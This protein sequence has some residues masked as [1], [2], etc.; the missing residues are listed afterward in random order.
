[1]TTPALPDGVTP[2]RE[3]RTEAGGIPLH[4]VPTWTAAFPW[5]VHGTTGA[6][7]GPDEADGR[8][9]GGPGP[10]TDLGLFGDVPAGVSHHRWA[11]LRDGLGVGR[12]VHS[13][14]VHS[15]RIME[16]MERLP[17]LFV[18]DGYD[19]HIT[20][21]PGIL[22]TVSVA[23]CVPIFLVDPTLQRVGLLHGGWRGTAAGIVEAGIEAM[24]SDPSRLLAH[25]GPAICG[26]CYEVGPEV[27]E[28]LGL[29][30]PGSPSPVDLRAVQARRL[31]AGGVPAERV[32]VSRWCVKHDDG[33]YS[34]RGGHG[35]R[36]LG[37]LGVRR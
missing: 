25:L 4:P 11:A 2:V 6:G 34:H 3:P 16:H 19:G 20:G 32:S 10:G 7:E 28:G 31:V 37:V 1:M 12:A 9:D 5:L 21:Y 36:Q 18:T 26:R 29:E 13:R 17:G 30:V 22:L 27:H 24:G 8:A 33:F 23:D 15:A 14:Q 35:G